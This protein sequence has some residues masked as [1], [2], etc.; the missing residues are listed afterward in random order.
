MSKLVDFRHNG[1]LREEGEKMAKMKIEIAN[2]DEV[3]KQ[4]SEI[5]S[6][7]KQAE[8]K[9]F[10]LEKLKIEIVPEK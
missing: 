4:I 10:Q 1:A 9:L 7:I 3:C 6:L 2:Y 8:I 5:N